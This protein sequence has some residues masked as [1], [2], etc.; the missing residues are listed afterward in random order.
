MA[1]TARAAESNL[2]SAPDTKGARTRCLACVC[3]VRCDCNSPVLAVVVCVCVCVIHSVSFWLKTQPEPE[4]DCGVICQST[5]RV[6]NPFFVCICLSVHSLHH[7]LCN[8][9]CAYN[10]M[11]S[12]LF[13]VRRVKCAIDES[14]VRWL[15]QQLPGQLQSKRRR[16]KVCVERTHAFTY[17]R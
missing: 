2:R 15:S 13:G 16:I 4:R 11:G 1:R 7:E 8:I 5:L 10:I 6:Q 9:C 12:A 14:V 3:G 17:G